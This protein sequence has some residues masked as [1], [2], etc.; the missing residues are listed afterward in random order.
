[1]RETSPANAACLTKEF[2]LNFNSREPPNFVSV[3]NKVPRPLLSS[4]Q[5][6][7]GLFNF[8]GNIAV[9][10]DIYNVTV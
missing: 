10:F 4:N 9:R 6:N 2:S 3:L 7:K 5:V 8:S 1:M